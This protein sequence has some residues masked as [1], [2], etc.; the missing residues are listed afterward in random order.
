MLNPDKVKAVKR[1]GSAENFRLLGHDREAAWG[2]GSIVEVKNNHAYIGAVGGS[3]DIDAEWKGR[4]TH[5][6][7]VRVLL[8][9]TPDQ[10]FPDT[11][12]GRSALRFALKKGCTQMVSMWRERCAR[13]DETLILLVPLPYGQ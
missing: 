10:R 1:E 7:T 8:A 9:A 4:G 13:P 12:S 5:T 11:L 6:D 2:G 3:W